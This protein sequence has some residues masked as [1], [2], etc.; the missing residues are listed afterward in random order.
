MLH[1][2]K[3]D[4]IA[5]WTPIQFSYQKFR[6]KADRVGYAEA[7][8]SA[9]ELISRK[10]ALSPIV[11]RMCDS[12]VIKLLSTD[13]F[14]TRSDLLLSVTNERKPYGELSAPFVASVGSGY[15]F[16]ETGLVATDNGSLI[17][18]NL[19]PPNRGRR[20][21]VAKL[22]WQL[23]FEQLNL[24]TALARKDMG[25][26]KSETI[27][28]R[29]VAPLIPRYTDNYYHW[30]IETVPQIR[31]L[32]EFEAETGIEVTYFVPRDAPS[33]LEETLELLEIPE[34]KLLH[35]T[36]RVYHVEQLILPS[37]P[38]Q[39]QN[40]YQW[41]VDRVSSNMVPTQAKICT[42][43]NVYISR[44]NAVERHVVNEE[45]IME[46]LSEYG[47]KRYR[48][49]E[50]SVA[51]NVVLFKEADAIVGAHGAGLTDL[52]YCTDATVVE[53]FGSKIKT[54]YQRLAETMDIPY[55]SV[56]CTPRSTDIYVD[57]DMLESIIKSAV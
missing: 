35:A 42:G 54:P 11:G 49:E 19:F 1:A 47:F 12:G 23:F 7:I 48:L 45:E 28:N 33:W 56:E 21:I 9:L 44:R 57:P 36:E 37:F 4:S 41:I 27:T 30:T 53:L 31:Y 2:G 20:F 43:S 52:I 15:I 16:T 18:H 22:I 14:Q 13:Q 8:V 17:N 26:V 24:T 46:V 50:H 38:V 5:M 10:K 25:A 55:K 40:D 29:A 51:E 3:L 39:T 34:S 32:Q 6:R